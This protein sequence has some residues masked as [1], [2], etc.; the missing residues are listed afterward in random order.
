[1]KKS[2]A[3][4]TLSISGYRTDV[5]LAEEV[6]CREELLL[7]LLGPLLVE[8]DF[9]VLFDEIHN[10]VRSLLLTSPAGCLSAETSSPC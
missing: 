8:V 9:H 6:I 7:D 3:L 10:Y 4:A 5:A 2:F 1:M